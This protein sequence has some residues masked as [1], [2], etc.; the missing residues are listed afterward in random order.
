MYKVASVKL[1]IVFDFF[2]LNLKTT[3][4]FL[5]KNKTTFKRAYLLIFKLFSRIIYLK[6][7]K[8]NDREIYMVYIKTI[9]EENF[10]RTC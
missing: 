4:I 3:L 9:K 5:I 1:F 2:F 10:M 7:W 8:Y 6:N